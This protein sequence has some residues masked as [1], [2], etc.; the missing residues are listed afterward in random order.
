MLPLS[1]FTSVHGVRRL[2]SDFLGVFFFDDLDEGV[3][4]FLPRVPLNSTS[5][6]LGSDV[7]EDFRSEDDRIGE[8]RTPASSSFGI[9]EIK[10]GGKEGINSTC[11]S[12]ALGW[13]SSNDG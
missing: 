2:A 11:S 4:D 5:S 13:S 6:F 9:A 7:D 1:T 10:D 3:P 8:R 12:S